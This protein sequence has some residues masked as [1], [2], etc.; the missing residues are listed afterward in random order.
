MEL[1]DTVMGKRLIEGTLPEIANQ[2]KKLADN[3]NFGKSEWIGKEVQIYP[4][5]TR[6]KWGKVVGMNDAGVTFLITRYEGSDREWIVGKHKFISYS[7]KLS[8][9]EI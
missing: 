8:F 6:S 5:D 7:A 2:L 4:G 3:K 9:I 1:H